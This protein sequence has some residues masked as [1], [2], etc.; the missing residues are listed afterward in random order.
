MTKKNQKGGSGCGSVCRV[1][2]SES[3][4]P[5]FESRHWQTFILDISLLAYLLSSVLKRQK[6]R[7]R[8]WEWPF[9]NKTQLTMILFWYK[10]FCET[11]RYNP[12]K[13][14]LYSWT[15]SC[16]TN[17]KINASTSKTFHST[18]FVAWNIW[19]CCPRFYFGTVVAVYANT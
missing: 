17:V 5:Q 19:R 9:L 11:K 13:F 6:Y 15:L 8:G 18:F 12:L 1:V 16:F 2:A 4:G 14:F 7:K 3:R 10:I